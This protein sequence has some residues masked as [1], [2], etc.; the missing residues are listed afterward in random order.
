VQCAETLS[1]RVKK[2][3]WDV[4]YGEDAYEEGEGKF[5]DRVV[6]AGNSPDSTNPLPWLKAV[7]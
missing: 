2:R 1:S 6:R 7:S 4:F 3:G 5:Q